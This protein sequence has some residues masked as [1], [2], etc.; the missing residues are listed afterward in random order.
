MI[1]QPLY[2]VPWFQR[3]G[4]R[5]GVREATAFLEVFFACTEGVSKNNLA[6]CLERGQREAP[7]PTAFELGRATGYNL[8]LVANAKK[9][10]V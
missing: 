3:R 5:V 7:W 2:Q 10:R 6:D 8:T 1:L 4:Y 9:L